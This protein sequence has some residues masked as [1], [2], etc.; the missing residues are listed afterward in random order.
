M[1]ELAG[2]LTDPRNAQ[3]AN[4][5]DNSPFFSGSTN[6]NGTAVVFC[7]TYFMNICQ[8]TKEIHIDGTFKVGPRSPPSRQLFNVMGMYYD[9]VRP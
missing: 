6:G 4:N 3:H 9:K 8:V 1:A 5:M 7:S 2:M